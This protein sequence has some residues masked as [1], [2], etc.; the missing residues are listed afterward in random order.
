MENNVNS[1]T[2]P[3]TRRRHNLGSRG[4]R[5]LDAPDKQSGEGLEADCHV[6]FGGYLM[7][8]AVR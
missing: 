8:D 3:S 1:S 2:N 7:I 6:D 5:P 4:R